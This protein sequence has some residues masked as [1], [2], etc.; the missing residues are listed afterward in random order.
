MDTVSF[1]GMMDNFLRDNGG[2]E[3]KT[4]MESGQEQMAAIM[5]VTGI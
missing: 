2:W 3:Q 4:V 1:D 5:K